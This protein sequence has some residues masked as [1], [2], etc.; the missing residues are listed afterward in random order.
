M[1][2]NYHRP[3]KP[4]RRQLELPCYLSKTKATE[5]G[6]TRLISTQECTGQFTWQCS[7]A[8][9]DNTTNPQEGG[10][11]TCR[12][13]R[14]QEKISLSGSTPAHVSSYFASSFPIPAYKPHLEYPGAGS[15]LMK[16]SVKKNGRNSV[17]M[18]GRLIF[19]MS[20]NSRKAE[21]TCFSSQLLLY[22]FNL[23]NILT[24]LIQTLML[25]SCKWHILQTE[26]FT[27]LIPGNYALNKWLQAVGSNTSPLPS[28][29]S[30]WWYQ[31][32]HLF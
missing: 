5:T 12:E 25:L 18:S 31:V 9:A 14:C 22:F 23:Y 16:H 19:F 2:L 27:L 4:D 21:L 6:T 11:P 3:W 1:Q 29:N 24:N 8:S 17:G 13:P 28:L 30:V 32:F 7:P 15:L 10:G 26:S 20:W